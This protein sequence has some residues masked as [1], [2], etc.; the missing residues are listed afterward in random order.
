MPCYVAISN[1]SHMIAV[2]IEGI[3]VR[4]EFDGKTMTD[5]GHE[6]TSGLAQTETKSL[7]RIAER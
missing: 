3:L 1:E 4:I 7:P 2:A 5:R 6:I